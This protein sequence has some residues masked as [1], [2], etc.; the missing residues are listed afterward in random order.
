VVCPP[1][2][3]EQAGVLYFAPPAV[4]ANALTKGQR[5]KIAAKN[6]STKKIVLNRFGGDGAQRAISS[7]AVSAHLS[8]SNFHVHPR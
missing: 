2:D 7:T 8:Y 3:P 6:A 5:G 1:S 4:S